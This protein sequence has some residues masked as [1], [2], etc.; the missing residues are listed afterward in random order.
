MSPA[1]RS[2]LPLT[3]T[4][5]KLPRDWYAEYRLAQAC[6][7]AGPAVAAVWCVLL[8]QACRLKGVFESKEALL[9]VAQALDIGLDLTI[10][11]SAVEALIDVG[12]LQ[13]SGTGFEVRDWYLYDMP[14]SA[15]S[16]ANREP[17]LTG[18][19]PQSDVSLIER[20]TRGKERDK[21]PGAVQIEMGTDGVERAFIEKARG[22]L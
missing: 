18:V 5:L 13:K 9:M 8:G 7:M 3:Q 19:R 16:P 21:A 6:R 10:A 17:R 4:W 11:Q 20:G 1:Q 15:K 14:N 2:G 22:R 12:L